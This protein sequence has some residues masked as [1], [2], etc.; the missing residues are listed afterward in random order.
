M[1]EKIDSELAVYWIVLEKA[2]VGLRDVQRLV[3]FSSPSSALYHLDRL[4]NQGLISKDQEGRYR[5]AKYIKRGLLNS[6]I[7]LG[8]HLVPKSL[9]YALLLSIVDFAIFYFS[10]L[11]SEMLLALTPALL[12]TLIFWYETYDLT[13]YKRRIFERRSNS[14]T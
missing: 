2:P 13:R 8:R 6:F 3:G 10:N 11:R 14:R 7:L 12:A 9:V 1:N 4:T 5:V